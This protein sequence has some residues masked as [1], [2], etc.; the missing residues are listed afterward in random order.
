MFI[1][2][3]ILVFVA[4][5][6]IDYCAVNYMKTAHDDSKPSWIAANWGV[7]QWTAATIGFVVAVKCTM[8]F[9][10]LEGLGLWLG[11]YIAL[12]SQKKKAKIALALMSR[13]V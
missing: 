5:F 11:S 4:S 3:G 8:W 1:L 2:L 6:A 13:G 10:I 7:L 9:L 12:E